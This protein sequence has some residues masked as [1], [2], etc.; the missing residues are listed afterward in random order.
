MYAWIN[1]W[2]NNREAGDLRLQHGHYDVIVMFAHGIFKCI[3]VNGIFEFD[4][5][6]LKFV[7]MVP[8]IK[9]PA[10]VQVMAWH[11]ID[12]EPLYANDGLVYW[13]MYA[14]LGLRMGLRIEE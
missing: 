5:N 8:I 2:V 10:L 12:D 11:R 6:S 9:M 1:D 14:S 13:C 3:F 4:S 7:Y